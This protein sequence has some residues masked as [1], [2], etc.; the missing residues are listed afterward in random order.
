MPLTFETLNITWMQF[1]S[2]L[3]EYNHFMESEIPYYVQYTFT[4][5]VHL[6]ADGYIH[7]Y[8]YVHTFMCVHACL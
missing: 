1:R 7:V 6:D 5:N 8:T 4:I 2:N 3:E